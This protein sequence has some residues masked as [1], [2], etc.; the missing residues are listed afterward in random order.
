MRNFSLAIQRYETQ[1]KR[2][3]GWDIDISAKLW[4]K[5]GS[6]SLN[7]KVTIYNSYLDMLSNEDTAALCFHQSYSSWAG[8]DS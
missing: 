8:L 2:Y 1:L 4:D 3:F 7:V 6:R 5:D